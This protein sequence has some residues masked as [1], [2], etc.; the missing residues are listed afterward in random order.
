MNTRVKESGFTARPLVGAVLIVAATLAFTS[1]SIWIKLMYQQSNDIDAIS[2]MALRIGFALPIYLFIAIGLLVRIRPRAFSAETVGQVLLLSFLGYYLASYLD[3]SGLAFI[4][5]GLERMI[6]YLY[7]TLVV[8]MLC[9][10]E[11]RAVTKAEAMA[12]LLSYAGITLVFM[13]SFAMGSE[14]LVQGSLLVFAS[15]VSFSIFTVKSVDTIRQIG[16]VR[17]TV[18][19][20]L[21]G[22]MMTLTHYGAIHGIEIPR[23]SA[24]VYLLALVLAIVATV[25]PSFL[26][27]EGI[28][29]IGPG[30]SSI[31]GSIGPVST[32]V[33]GL[34]VLSEP[35]SAVQI[36]GAITII[37]GVISLGRSKRKL[38]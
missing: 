30:R 25:I 19:T 32:I 31:L 22:S 29:H 28:R 8:L 26:M 5:A 7:P 17:F 16:S 38:F 10:Q 21:A 9:R 13:D 20:M 6:L 12:L 24:K 27:A 15:A 1:K 36:V 23:Y 18:S 3:I 14:H 37:A 35:V 4:S 34:I 33:L 2:I 11:K